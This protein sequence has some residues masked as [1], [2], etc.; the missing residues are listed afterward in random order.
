VH[1]RE[2]PLS[3]VAVGSGKC[4]EEFEALRRVLIS[5]SRH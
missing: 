2:S 4:L 5:S 3:W 1:I